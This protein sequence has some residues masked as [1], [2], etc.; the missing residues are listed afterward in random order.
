MKPIRQLL[1]K[2]DARSQRERLLILFLGTAF[3]WALFDIGLLNPR[4]AVIKTMV[5]AEST[6]KAKIKGWEAE[7]AGI[8]AAHKG[9]SRVDIQRKKTDLE[10]Q[11]SLLNTKLMD[12]AAHV[13]PPRAM[14][15]LL[16][17]A[18][19]EN[20]EL[21]LISIQTLPVKPMPSNLFM[22]P[23]VLVFEGNYFE[24]LNYLQRIEH[25]RWRFF[26]DE[27]DYV[28]TKYPNAQ[29]TLKLHTLSE[30]ASWLDV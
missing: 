4:E 20:K 28:V 15:T 1:D 27:L 30:K 12:I 10:N 7:I 17:E 25:L 24:T 5:E 26:W 6:I 8:Q 19:L 13:V 29:I 16:E 18:L 22:H 9:G 11:L 14:A 2:I 23:L 3:L 21:R